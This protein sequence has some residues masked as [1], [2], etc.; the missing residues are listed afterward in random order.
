MRAIVGADANGGAA[1]G[2]L[3]ERFRADEA[4]RV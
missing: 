3:D 2:I 4:G 1:I